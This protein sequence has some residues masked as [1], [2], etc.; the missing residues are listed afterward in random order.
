MPLDAR[1]GVTAATSVTPPA[2]KDPA[3]GTDKG[4]LD[5]SMCS[6]KTK[7]GRGKC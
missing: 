6:P 4:I 3:G 1:S 5:F 7:W 2:T